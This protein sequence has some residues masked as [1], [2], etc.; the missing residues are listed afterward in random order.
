MM[1]LAVLKTRAK[2]L[3]LPLVCLMLVGCE[4]LRSPL[5]TFV[6][7][8]DFARDAFFLFKFAV[9]WD[10]LILLTV[11]VPLVLALFFLTP[12]KPGGGHE[13]H[14][15]HTNWL[16]AAWTITPALILISM[17]VPSIKWT[18]QYQ[19]KN[20]PPGALRVRVIGHQW[21]WEFQYP[22]YH[23]TTA[24]ELHLPAGR[25][26]FFDLES[27]D[28]LH[29][30]WVPELAGKRDNI[31]GHV[32]HI[33]FTPDHPGEY[34]GQCTQFCGLSH[35]NMRFR[36]FVDTP[37][38]FAA[39]V[40]QEQAAPATGQGSNPKVEAGAAIFAAAPC[41]ACHTIEGVSKGYIGPNLS[42][43]GSHQ[44]LAGAILSNTPENMAKWIH[45]PDALKPGVQM[46]ALG[47]NPAD[48]SA[49]VAY[50]E[51]LK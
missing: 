23:V 35:A 51:S 49:L 42:H 20:P 27:V 45:N 38:K 1:R 46:P 41:V 33:M 32:N 3:I 31:P 48:M 50:L 18:F 13:A 39:W 25:V 15:E 12:K 14:A 30:F 19:P 10:T 29:G 21:W 9:F 26:A 22:E 2:R 6:R 40:K 28:V 36:V 24:D 8:S 47:L 16:E 43:I 7:D 44:T 34:F 37:E 5:T 17:V 4:P 11:I